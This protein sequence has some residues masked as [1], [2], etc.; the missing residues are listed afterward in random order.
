MSSTFKELQLYTDKEVDNCLQSVITPLKEH[1]YFPSDSSSAGHLSI[2]L[3]N[4]SVSETLTCNTCQTQLT[5]RVE[6]T[7]HYKSDWHR[8]NIK[9]KLRGQ[10]IISSEK[11]EDIEKDLSSISGSGSSSDTD[12]NSDSYHSCARN[13]PKI[14]FTLSDGRYISVY[15]CLL[16]GKKNIP[17]ESEQL[18]QNA[19][20][21]PRKI[22][23]AIIM[24]A[25]GHFAAALFERD[26]IIQHKT[27]HKYVVRAKQGTAQALH[28]NKGGKAKSA[29]ANLRRQNMLHLK[30]KIHELFTT[31]KENIAK[32]SH[33]FIRAPS[34][35]HQLI[36]GEKDAPFSN[37][38]PRIR[39][40]PFS[41]FRPT[42]NEI[43][44]VYNQLTR[45]EVYPQDFQFE[46]ML[47]QQPVPVEEE[48][49]TKFTLSSS[50][51]KNQSESDD[52]EDDDIENTP[53]VQQKKEE[54]R[55]CPTRNDAQF[56][57]VPN[58]ERK[59]L[60]AD[61][62]NTFNE[63]F[64]AVR[65]NDIQRFEDLLSHLKTLKT[66]P[67]LNNKVTYEDV[68]NYQTAG[69]FDTLVHIASEKGYQKIVWK[70]LL[71]GANPSYNNCRGKYPYNLAKNKETKD[72]FRR[73]KHD[74]PDKYDYDQGQ[75]TTSISAEVMD[76]QRQTEREKRRKAKTLKKEKL[77]SDQERKLREEKEENER[78]Q[79]VSLTDAEKK[80]LAVRQNFENKSSPQTITTT[81][82]PNLIHLSRCWQCG[83]VISKD[84]FEYY[85]YKFC[86]IQCL[87]AHRTKSKTKV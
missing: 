74:Y 33:V 28:D 40:I 36:L 70:L 47:K 51:N 37:H 11:F 9:Q 24:L 44:R 73:F 69:S 18:V 83:T 29:G 31:W 35:N 41:T 79:F 60:L 10:S 43:K 48:K 49:T 6:Q 16:H 7:V 85:D 27:F 54:A 71:E 42:F 84:P 67:S 38:D 50:R 82:E 75:I 68:L 81:T 72:T 46:I 26:K 20:Q 3:P 14:I 45:V 34:F 5:D 12:E 1:V 2:A 21:L 64:T 19:Q 61:D 13:N 25:G 57:Q 23:W 78:K 4:L 8:F 17:Q 77:R 56:K 52:S 59:T 76:K 30:Q 32:C 87:K 22:Y 55:A 62:L 39:S 58:S 63:L 15:R 80:T 66:I 65:L 86:S 53:I